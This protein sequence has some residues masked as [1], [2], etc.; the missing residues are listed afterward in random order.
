ML[1]SICDYI[2]DCQLWALVA[3]FILEPSQAL[4]AEVFTDVI[5][6]PQPN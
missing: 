4:N 1:R 2:A 5:L 6:M 3:D